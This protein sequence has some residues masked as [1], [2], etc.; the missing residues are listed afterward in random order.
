M[1][2]DVLN[3]FLTYVDLY[4]TYLRDALYPVS[5]H[6]LLEEPANR[7]KAISWTEREYAAD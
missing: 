2:F 6:V 7:H 5:D 1:L 3:L 4:Y